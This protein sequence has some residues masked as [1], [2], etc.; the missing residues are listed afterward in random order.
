MLLMGTSWAA[1]SRSLPVGGLVL[2]SVLVVL[3]PQ[4]GAVPRGA[5]SAIDSRIGAADCRLLGRSYMPGRGCRRD[6]CLP[7]AHIVNRARGAELCALPHQGDYAYGSPIDFRRCA[8]L[9]REWIAQVNWCAS[10]PDRSKAVIRHAPQ[11]TGS[12]TTYITHT[13]RVGFYDECL[14]PGEV[15]RLTRMARRNGST[16]AREALVRSPTCAPTGPGTSS[17]TAAAFGAVAPAPQPVV[18]C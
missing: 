11:C 5:S 17:R 12:A 10:N 2:L 7:S 16:L 9:H 3:A 4:A 14:K 18:S 8:A 13:E 15:R 1:V 6:D